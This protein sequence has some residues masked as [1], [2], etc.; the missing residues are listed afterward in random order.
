MS[1]QELQAIEKLA[2][3]CNNNHISAE[4]I[5]H[6]RDWYGIKIQGECNANVPESLI[7]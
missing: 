5:D 6:L 7:S 4:L 3:D 2:Q 1:K